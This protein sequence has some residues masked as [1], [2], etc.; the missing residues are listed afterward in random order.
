MFL[1]N[2]RQ[3]SFHLNTSI[4]P[5]NKRLSIKLDRTFEVRYRDSDVTG[6]IQRYK[7][8]DIGYRAHVTWY[9]YWEQALE[10]FE[11]SMS[12]SSVRSSL[13]ETMLMSTT[14]GI[15]GHSI[16]FLS[17]ASFRS[18]HADLSLHL[19]YQLHTKLQ[20]TILHDRYLF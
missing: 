15:N 18:L 14:I 16:Q 20:P 13:I 10:Y 7:I 12:F 5:R 8:Q 19:N 4:W 6:L 3:E 2:K 11:R 17:L 9:R 1:C